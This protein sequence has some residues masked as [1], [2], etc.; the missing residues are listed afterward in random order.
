MVING[1]QPS[2][3]MSNLEDDNNKQIWFFDD[4]FRIALHWKGRLNYDNSNKMGEF[5]QVL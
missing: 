5:F 1:G 3:S 4:K 2:V